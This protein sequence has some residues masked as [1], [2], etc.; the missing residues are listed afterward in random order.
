MILSILWQR[1]LQRS[2][3]VL[4][5]LLL[6]AGLSLRAQ[7]PALASVDEVVQMQ[8]LAPDA[9]IQYGSEPLQFGYLRLPVGDGPHPVVIVIHG[10]CW[11]AQYD[12]EH[13]GT[14]AEA[15][16]H[17]GFATW[18]VEYRRVGN[19][20]GG[21]PGTFLDVARGTD[22]LRQLA[23]RY[24]L[25]LDRVIILGH[26]AGG[27]LALWLGA[28]PRIPSDSPLYSPDPLPVKGV[29]AL[30]AVPE[31][32]MAYAAKSCD[33][34]MQKLVGGSPEEYPK[35]Y[36]AA[37]PGNLLPLGV[38]QILIS[39]KYDRDWFRFGEAYAKRAREAGDPVRFVVAPESGHFEVILPASSTWP[40][41]TEALHSL[42][43]EET[44]G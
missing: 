43:A 42:F 5:L 17:E 2:F 10:G 26:S 41:V 6:S 21:W 34:A 30:A 15:L 22:Y 29:L 23:T 39:G 37:A 12:L 24:P 16:T 14:A 27:H 38:S 35:R 32:E 13:I 40:L 4:S 36:A 25:D 44:D 1:S 11:L 31:L 8:A 20:G 33:W 19:E 18:T 7:P 9:R 28:R 3:F